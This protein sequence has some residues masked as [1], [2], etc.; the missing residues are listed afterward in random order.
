MATIRISQ[1]TAVSQATDDD[2]LI[3]NDAD[4]NTRKI[5]FGNLTQGLLNTSSTAQTKSGALTVQGLFNVS[6]NLAVK[7]NVLF[8]DSLN[9]R[10]GIKTNTPNADLDINGIL[11]IQGANPIRFGDSDNSNFV[12]LRAPS[13]VTSNFTFTLPAAPPASTQL[14][15][16]DAAGVF[17]FTTGIGTGNSSLSLGLVELINQGVVRFY[18]SSSNGTNNIS[19]AAPNNLSN[20][21]SY[22]LP[23]AF[24]PSTGFILSS[25][26]TGELS[27]ISSSSGASGANNLIQFATN[28]LLNSNSN[29]SFN[30]STNLLSSTN[31]N[32]SGDLTVQGNTQLGTGST[33]TINP[34]GVFNNH[35]LP[36]PN[37]H[38]LGSAFRFWRHTYTQ[39]LSVSTALNPHNSNTVNIGS[40][41]SRW[42][43]AFVN[44]LQ[45]QGVNQRGVDSFSIAGSGTSSVNLG[46]NSA[47]KVLIKAVDTVTDDIELIEQLVVSDGNGAISEVT[48]SN[49]QAPTPGNF[50]ISASSQLVGADV[51]MTITNSSSNSLTVKLYSVEM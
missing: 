44:N 13:V 25:S 42:Q 21:F 35:L 46:A 41:S 38:D 22:T 23:T 50:L 3:I 9:D 36:E 7:N 28:G 24:P 6:G 16:S 15:T 1:L 26:S 43:T 20:T 45:L 34:L 11:H 49:V 12:G 19:F 2:V 5:T 29:L 37:T 51:V 27:W 4:T 8:V 33:Q 30:P 10:V 40:S 31:G 32:F 14:V 17:S 48:G 18:E 39:S 47:Y